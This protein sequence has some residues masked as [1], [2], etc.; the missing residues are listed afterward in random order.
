MMHYTK[1]QVCGGGYLT[2]AFHKLFVV[3]VVN[4]TKTWQKVI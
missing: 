1:G 2:N 3:S 4:Y